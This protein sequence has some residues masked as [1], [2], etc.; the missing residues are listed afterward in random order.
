LECSP[1]NGGTPA[2]FVVK[3]LGFPSVTPMTCFRETLGTILARSLGVR[4]PDPGL[5]NIDK[6][7]VNSIEQ[8]HALGERRMEPGLCFGSRYLGRGLYAPTANTRF[9][10]DE[11]IDSAVR[12]FGFDLAFQN[13][14]R[15]PTNPNCLIKDDAIVAFDFERSFEFTGWRKGGDIVPA[16]YPNL[17]WGAKTHVFFRVA[18]KQR[19]RLGSFVDTLGAFDSTSLDTALLSLPSDWGMNARRIIQHVQ[20]I[21][22]GLET[23]RGNLLG[24]ASP[25]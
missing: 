17:L 7:F 22:S 12:V 15:Q 2:L 13:C 18:S 24:V 25:P 21:Q 9:D 14:D 23:F 4:V 8:V 5:I 6:A 1:I 10:T 3:P 16:C 11:M 19:A 20:E